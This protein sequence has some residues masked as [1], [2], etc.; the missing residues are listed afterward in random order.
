MRL[1]TYISV[2]EPIFF[3]SGPTFPTLFSTSVTVECTYIDSFY[4]YRYVRPK[5]FGSRAAE[6]VIT[7]TVP[8]SNIFSPPQHCFYMIPVRIL[9]ISIIKPSEVTNKF[10]RVK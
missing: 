1:S 5:F 4:N 3:N 6:T 9:R 8:A 2:A 7:L 10:D